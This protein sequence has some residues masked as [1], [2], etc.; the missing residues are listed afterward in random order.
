[1]D[2]S[3]AS[4]AP[5]MGWNTGEKSG[6]DQP[7]PY[8][9]CL[10]GYNPVQGGYPIS[11]QAGY[12]QNLLGHPYGQLCD[13]QIQGPYPSLSAVTV[14]PTVHV[15]SGPLIPPLPDYL[16]YSIFTL[17]CCC[18]PLGIAALVY[19]ISTRDANSYGNRALA[20]RNSRLALNLNNS[21][22]GIGVVFIIVYI[23]MVFI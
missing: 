20:E 15:T 18:L 21:A 3:K 10:T 23:I 9:E 12:P 8:S 4:P 1:M 2:P 7:P 6:M 5:P 11:N 14:Q 19:S 16:C 13:G 22:L 17:L